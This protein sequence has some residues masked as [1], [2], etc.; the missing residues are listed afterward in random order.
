MFILMFFLFFV[1]EKIRKLLK[2][3]KMIDDLLI[4]FF[5]IMIN[6]KSF[7]KKSYS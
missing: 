7:L 6:G 4:L 1:N 5:F 2:L 3:L